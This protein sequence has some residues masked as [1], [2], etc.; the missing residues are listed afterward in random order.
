MG[1]DDRLVAAEFWR[2]PYPLFE[3]LRREAPVWPLPG[4]NA[5]FV[6][7]WELVADATRRVQDFSNHFRYTAFCHDDGTLGFLETGANGPDVFAGEDP[8]M[9]T[10]QRKIFF[11]ELVQKKI[12]AI[13]P[14][15]VELTDELLDG[16]LSQGVGDAATELAH[17]LPMRVVADKVIGFREPDF[18]QI[19][20]WMFEGSRLVGGLMT[21]DR[22]ASLSGEVAGMMPWTDAQLDAAIASST[23]G[24]V[25]SAAAAAVRSGSLTHEEASFTLMVLVGAGAETTTSLIGIAIGLLAERPDLQEQLRA[26]VT[27]VPAFIEEVLR[28]DSPFRYHPRTA[29]RTVELD[30]V[31]IPEGALVVLLWSAANRDDRVFERPDDLLLDR[32]NTHL[33]FGFGRGVHHCVGAP[34]ARLEARVVLTRLLERT[35]SF[36]RNANRPQAW[37][38]SIWIHRHEQLPLVMEAS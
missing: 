13:E 32:P 34:L 20:R 21:L 12:D 8:P 27:R 35:T 15:V 9:H 11:S 16:L 6:S 25:L 29:A 3:R 26:D 36:E 23:E 4:E 7:T 33:H 10:A 14:Y 30:G 24:D 22:M 38:D 19:R 17:L 5:F 18:D 28:F 31:K 1:I 37:A 2:D